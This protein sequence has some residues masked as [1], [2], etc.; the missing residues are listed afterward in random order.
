MSAVAFDERNEYLE[1]ALRRD[2]IDRFDGWGRIFRGKAKFAEFTHQQWVR[3]V[4]E[5]QVGGQWDDWLKY[6]R[7][8][9]GLG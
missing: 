2:K 9:Y 5:H 8:R 3:W 6:V 7:E 1:A 4:Q